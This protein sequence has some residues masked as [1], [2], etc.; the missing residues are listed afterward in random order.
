MGIPTSTKTN[1]N[2]STESITISVDADV[3]A[4][5]QK[6]GITDVN[7]YIAELIKKE[8][9]RQSKGQDASSAGEEAN[10]FATVKK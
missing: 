3:A 5:I 2:T 10:E 1:V 6:K 4:F 9:V 7:S 8:Q